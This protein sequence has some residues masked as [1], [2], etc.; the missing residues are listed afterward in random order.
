MLHRNIQ[1]GR[2]DQLENQAS[3]HCYGTTNQRTGCHR[4]ER[5][6]PERAAEQ[7]SVHLRGDLGPQH[8]CGKEYPN[9]SRTGVI[10]WCTNSEYGLGLRIGG[11]YGP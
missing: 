3:S 1:P 7:Q 9:G 10:A 6:P 4:D 11:L 2:R 8:W 5:S